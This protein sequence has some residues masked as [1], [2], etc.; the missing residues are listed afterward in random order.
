MSH[1]ITGKRQLPEY[2][3]LGAERGTLSLEM[4]EALLSCSF[5]CRILSLH[6]NPFHWYQGF[7]HKAYGCTHWNNSINFFTGSLTITLEDLAGLLR[8]GPT[9]PLQNGR[10]ISESW[11]CTGRLT[12]KWGLFWPVSFPWQ[13]IIKDPYPNPCSTSWG[14][15][16]H[17][18][19]TWRRTG[20]EISEI[21]DMNTIFP[22]S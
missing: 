14:K 3:G 16:F 6:S 4:T 1:Q 22:G 9:D 2:G 7:W 21:I 11:W 5:S 12:I 18:K 20:E 10:F 17:H 15:R 8:W 13:V 19:V